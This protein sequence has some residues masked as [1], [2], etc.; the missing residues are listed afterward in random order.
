LAVLAASRFL[1][2][3]VDDA[4]RVFSDLAGRDIE[5]FYL[6]VASLRY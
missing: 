1:D 2:G 4:L 6:H 5:I 3:S